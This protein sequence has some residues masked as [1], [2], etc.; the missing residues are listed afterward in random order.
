MTLGLRG[1]ADLDLARALAVEDPGTGFSSSSSTALMESSRSG[2]VRPSS[3]T[4]PMSSRFTRLDRR[5]DL[6]MGDSTSSILYNVT[7][8][9]KV[10][11]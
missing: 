6:E 2:K 5:G 3:F 7:E 1:E 10:L 8:E 4:G 9:L 11:A